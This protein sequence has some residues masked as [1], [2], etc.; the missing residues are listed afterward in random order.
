MKET[1]ELSGST[2]QRIPRQDRG[3]RPRLVVLD[4]DGTTVGINELIPSERVCRAVRATIAAGVPVSVATGRPVWAALPTTEALGLGGPH[5]GAGPDASG[6]DGSGLDEPEALS[7]VCSNGSLVY[8][9]VA[10]RP[11]HR[12]FMDPA[13]ALRALAAA[14]PDAG[15]AVEHGLA[16]YRYTAR[17][18]RDF[19]ST[20]LDEVGLT[21]LGRSQTIR[22]SGRVPG[23]AVPTSHSRCEVATS[24]VADAGLDTARYSY[25]IGYSGWVDVSA[26]GVSKASGVALLARDL[27]VAAHEVL[28]I[29]DGSNDLSMFEWA[30]R[31]VAMGQAPSEVRAAADEVTA[32][33]EEDGVACVLEKWF[34]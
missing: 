7:M 10:H 18:P 12:R 4:L 33:V 24:W 5:A 13:P 1:A 29:G 32:S 19:P 9:V 25:E 26:P 16:G 17:F 14:R 8:D 11:V 6:L 27:G 2:G 31:S 20:F 34:G 30:G 15:F 22:L 3:W 21:E 28:V 23:V